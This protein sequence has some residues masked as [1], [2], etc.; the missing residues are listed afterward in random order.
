MH[1]KKVPRICPDIIVGSGSNSG[2][3]CKAKKTTFS[4][5]FGVLENKNW[6]RLVIANNEPTMAYALKSQSCISRASLESEG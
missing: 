3:T 6:L 4:Q 1:M 2:S 5:M